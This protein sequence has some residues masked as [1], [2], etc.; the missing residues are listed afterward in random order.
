MRMALASLLLVNFWMLPGVA[1]AVLPTP[2][3]ENANG[4]GFAYAGTVNPTGVPPSGLPPID[5][6]PVSVT[7][8]HGPGGATDVD[9]PGGILDVVHFGPGLGQLFTGVTVQAVPDRRSRRGSRRLSLTRRSSWSRKATASRGGPGGS[10]SMPPA[11]QT[12]SVPSRTRAARRAASTGPPPQVRRGRPLQPSPRSP[13]VQWSLSRPPTS[14]GSSRATASPRRR[15][16]SRWGHRRSRWRRRGTRCGA[17][18]G[19]AGSGDGQ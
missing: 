18:A 9:V 1:Q 14:M 4:S 13:F 5:M 19:P 16:T 10:S 6:G 17:G 15:C 8:T 2:G 3:V 7:T 11:P 12:S